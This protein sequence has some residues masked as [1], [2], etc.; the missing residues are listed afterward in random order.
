M[1]ILSS[2]KISV[3]VISIGNLTTGGTGKTP[4]T[5][6]I[7]SHFLK[8]NFNVGI[9][10]RGYGR[11]SDEMV[12]VFDGTTLVTDP[13][14]AGD[15]LIEISLRLRELYPNF[16]TVACADRVA[17]ANHIIELYKPDV[18]ILDDAFQHRKIKRDLD[19]LIIDKDN[20]ED[21]ENELLPA[22]SLRESKRGEE[23]A[24]AVIHN[25]KFKKNPIDALSSEKNIFT[26]TYNANASHLIQ[27]IGSNG[28]VA[29]SGIAKPE[30]FFNMLSDLNIGLKKRFEFD[31]HYNYTKEDIEKIVAECSPKDIIITTGKDLVKLN[32]FRNIF[33][34]IQLYAINITVSLQGKEEEFLNLLG[35]TV[36]K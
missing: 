10:S 36:T 24:D 29:V 16:V 25:Y 2:E 7:A 19:I 33:K 31:D 21:P 3:P 13:A 4:F 12:T 14:L 11:S 30:S 26:A 27:K 35:K 5:I 8:N 20:D 9:I 6:F 34:E 23:R 32:Q 15:E 28:V 17:A 1:D 18:I 22:G